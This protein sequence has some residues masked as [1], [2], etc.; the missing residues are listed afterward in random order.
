MREWIEERLDRGLQVQV[1]VSASNACWWLYLTTSGKVCRE[2]YGYVEDVA[3]VWPD[4]L[5]LKT[6]SWASVVRLQECLQNMAM[7]V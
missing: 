6:R 4:T 5:D 7:E 2:E 3:D 1:A